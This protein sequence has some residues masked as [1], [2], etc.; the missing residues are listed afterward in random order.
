[1]ARLTLDELSG[2]PGPHIRRVVVRE[3]GAW[4]ES[5]VGVRDAWTTGLCG[6]VETDP[7]C[8]SWAFE[9]VQGHP[10]IE[11]SAREAMWLDAVEDLAGP[12][13]ETRARR[14]DSITAWVMLGKG[15]DFRNARQRLELL[16]CSTASDRTS[17]HSSR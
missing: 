8:F 14:W 10:A 6:I 2:V 13:A 12:A 9:G 17:H 1:M 3:R 16:G 5:F 4:T 11:A 15:G 7:R